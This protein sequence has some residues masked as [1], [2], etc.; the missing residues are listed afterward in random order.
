MKNIL[1]NW[2]TWKSWNYQNLCWEYENEKIRKLSK[3][4]KTCKHEKV[5]KNSKH[6]KCQNMNIIIKNV[7]KYW[8]TRKC[9]KHWIYENEKSENFSK[10]WKTIEKH[11]KDW[12]YCHIAKITKY[13]GRG[14]WMCFTPEKPTG[15]SIV[16]TSFFT[17]ECPSLFFEA[18]NI[19]GHW[20][21]IDTIYW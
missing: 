16:K 3:N 8:K 10:A 6:W 7:K 19:N 2:K 18:P 4:E 17:T 9:Q 21:R 12:K 11:E 13:M 20:A 5:S 14:D 1:K 15:Q